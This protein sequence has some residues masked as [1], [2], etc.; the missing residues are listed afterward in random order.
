M[1]I[2]NYDSLIKLSMSEVTK[3]IKY[4]AIQTSDKDK[5]IK[6]KWIEDFKSSGFQHLMII[7]YFDPQHMYYLLR[8]NITQM[9]AIQLR[10]LLYVLS[11]Q[12][13]DS[14]QL[15]VDRTGE[16]IMQVI[17]EIYKRL[18]TLDI[19]PFQVNHIL[20]SAALLKVDT[21]HILDLI[22]TCEKIIFENLENLYNEDPS[23][24]LKTPTDVPVQYWRIRTRSYGDAQNGVLRLLEAKSQLNL[25]KSDTEMD[26]FADLFYTLTFKEK[27]DDYI[28]H[29]T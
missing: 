26:D 17:D 1:S 7:R 9:N 2:D 28:G 13:K 20:Q 16:G 23:L 14:Q 29:N 4:I 25:W 22:D 8:D 19:D 6:Y 27:K 5:P 12:T 21:P 10:N 18:S 11:R 15:A 3:D 24:W